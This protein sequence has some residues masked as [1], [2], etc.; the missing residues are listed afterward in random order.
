MRIIKEE[1]RKLKTLNVEKLKDKE[2]EEI[3]PNL[4]EYSNL[5]K[6]VLEEKGLEKAV[7]KKQEYIRAVRDMLENIQDM[8]LV[9]YIDH[10]KDIAKENKKKEDVEEDSQDDIE[11]LDEIVPHD[12]KRVNEQMDNIKIEQKITAL[13]NMKSVDK[14]IKYSIRF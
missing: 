10:L 3:N 6:E 9:E 1:M 8:N 7:Q 14:H 11:I 12:Q 2:S 13:L 5:I 4:A